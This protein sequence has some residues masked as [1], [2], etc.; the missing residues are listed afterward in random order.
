MAGSGATMTALCPGGG[1]T[2]C[3]LQHHKTG[4]GLASPMFSPYCS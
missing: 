2:Q 1:R 3:S 4:H